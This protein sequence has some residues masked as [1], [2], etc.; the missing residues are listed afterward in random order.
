MQAAYKNWQ[1]KLRNISVK[2]KNGHEC[3][4]LAFRKL[5]LVQTDTSWFDTNLVH[6]TFL[7]TCLIKKSNRKWYLEGFSIISKCNWR[8]DKWCHSTGPILALGSAVQKQSCGCSTSMMAATISDHPPLL[9]L[10]PV[11]SAVHWSWRRNVT[12]LHELNV[13]ERS[14]EKKRRKL[15]CLKDWAELK[16][17]DT[18]T[19]SVML[20]ASLRLMYSC[21][22]ADFTDVDRMEHTEY[23][24]SYL[25]HFNHWLRVRGTGN[26]AL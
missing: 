26:V 1:I 12:L 25:N 9:C 6:W 22:K 21:F 10:R 23:P 17:T 14:G 7:N 16:P 18:H 4:M 5:G 13:A 3:L 15:K 24:K 2:Y 11:M 8:Q 20:L 19:L